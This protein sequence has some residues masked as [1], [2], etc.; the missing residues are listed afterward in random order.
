MPK[1]TRPARKRAASSKKRSLPKTTTKSK[2]KARSKSPV[3]RKK[4]RSRPATRSRTRRAPL[5]AES[6][7]MFRVKS[8]KANLRSVAGVLD[9]ANVIA[10]LPR[11][12]A[13]GK[14]ADAS[15]PN[16]WEVSAM[17]EEEQLTGFI[18][19]TLL[20]SD[21]E[22]VAVEQPSAASDEV[23]VSDRALQMILEFEGMDQPSKW[24]GEQSGISLGHGYDLGFHSREEFR[25][26]WQPFLSAD[27]LNRLSNAI[28]RTGLAAK[29]IA[30]N[31][32]DITIK[33]GDADAVFMSS[34]LPKIKTWAARSFPGVTALPPDAQ[35]GLV[36]LVY[37][38]GEGMAGDRRREMREVRDTVAN[39][40][41][42]LREKLAS[43]AE[44]IRSMKRLWPDTLGL[45]RR[46]DAEADL[47]GSAA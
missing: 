36:S 10:V 46:R 3:S 31:Y 12:Q 8:E 43:I 21:E 38:R 32:R 6:V 42:S 44:S 47:I 14:I 2:T 7:E 39:S 29:N 22:V 23:Q 13:V 30:G 25:G 17:V 5:K 16:W 11:N 26:D 9:P 15:T 34:T 35:G 20:T 37:N 28:G 27:E 45:R 40:S 41:L 19:S 1:P 24:P 4:S 33:R 18:N